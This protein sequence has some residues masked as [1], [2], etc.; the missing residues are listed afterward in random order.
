M[1]VSVPIVSIEL[2]HFVSSKAIYTIVP[3]CIF[4]EILIYQYMLYVTLFTLKI[5]R[6]TNG[7]PSRWKNTDWISEIY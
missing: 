3:K 2:C 7:C 5:A 6:E 4:F 1:I